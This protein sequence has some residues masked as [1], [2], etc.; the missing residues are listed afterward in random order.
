MVGSICY[1][2]VG[3]YQASN[4]RNPLQRCDGFFAIWGLVNGQTIP[5]F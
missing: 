1:V 2:K 4:K 5:N 3:H